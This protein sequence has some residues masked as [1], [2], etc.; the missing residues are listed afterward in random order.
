MALGPGKYDEIC[1]KVREETKA[2]A[3]MVVIGGGD[4][5]NGFSLQASDIEFLLALPRI[6]RQ[7]ADEIEQSGLKA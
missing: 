4:K 7:I 2:T 6:L 3:A 1:T 5:G